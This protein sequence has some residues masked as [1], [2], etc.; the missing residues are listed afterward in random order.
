[1]VDIVHR[2]HNKHTT[3]TKAMSLVRHNSITVRAFQCPDHVDEHLTF[4]GT[5]D[6]M[7]D[8]EV[9]L[10]SKDQGRAKDM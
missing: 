5:W 3:S 6:V 10:K 8:P 9:V 1:M 2:T 7:L 4:H